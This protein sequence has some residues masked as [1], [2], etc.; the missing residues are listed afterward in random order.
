V[1]PFVNWSPLTWPSPEKGVPG[2]H[3][4]YPAYLDQAQ[5]SYDDGRQ[6]GR[7]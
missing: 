7:Q 5:N 1:N 6:K 4:L 3:Q 2:D